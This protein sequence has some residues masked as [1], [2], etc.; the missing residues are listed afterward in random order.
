MLSERLVRR[1]LIFVSLI[2]LAAG[3]GAAAIGHPDA[4]HAIWA[5]ATLP[6][7]LALALSIA[8]DLAAGRLGVDVIALL[9]MS[10]ALAL[11]QPLAGIVVA[12]MYTGGTVLEDFAVARAERSLKAL[13]DRAPRVATGALGRP[14]TTLTSRR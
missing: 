7:A 11:G 10:A 5:A 4:A 8:R 14:S 2:G 13:V 12:I 3:A 9:A 6:V 1:L